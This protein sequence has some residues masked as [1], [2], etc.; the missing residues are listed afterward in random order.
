MERRGTISIILPYRSL[1]RNGEG[2]KRSETRGFLNQTDVRVYGPKANWRQQQK[3][4][5]RERER[6]SGN[7]KWLE[8]GKQAVE[9]GNQGPKGKERKGKKITGEV[10]R[11]EMKRSGG[12]GWGLQGVEE[13]RQT[14]AEHKSKKEPKVVHGR[15]GSPAE[16]PSGARPSPRCRELFA[17][18]G[19]RLDCCG[20]G[21]VSWKELVPIEEGE[22][23]IEGEVRGAMGDEVAAS[24]AWRSCWP[25]SGS[26]SVPSRET[27]YSSRGTSEAENASAMMVENKAGRG[28]QRRE[29]QGG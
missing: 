23:T 11:G 3:E 17:A 24:H 13:E 1:T 19:A 8:D 18:G 15:R 28:R 10:R 25:I 7:A 21:E 22:E 26:S 4:R 29:R 16:S 12:D 14:R 5:E 27:F 20:G 9:R 6:K 2:K